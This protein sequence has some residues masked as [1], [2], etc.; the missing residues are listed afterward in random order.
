MIE[1]INE[2]PDFGPESSLDGLENHSLMDDLLVIREQQ[3]EEN[4]E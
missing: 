4:K 3:I 2:E 1:D